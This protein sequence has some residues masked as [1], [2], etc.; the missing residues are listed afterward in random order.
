CSS[1][2]S[3]SPPTSP[4]PGGRTARKTLR[5]TARSVRRRHTAHLPNPPAASHPT[6]AGGR[7]LRCQTGIASAGHTCS[8]RRSKE[9]TEPM[10]PIA[11][12][13][14]NEATH[15]TYRVDLPGVERPAVLTW[16]ARGDA[17]VADHTFVPDEMRGQGIA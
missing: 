5:P 13:R 6:L 10:S 17:R 16:H 2:P 12:T 8:E 14:I 9:E 3:P 1:P 4:Q 11:I 15:G 7:L